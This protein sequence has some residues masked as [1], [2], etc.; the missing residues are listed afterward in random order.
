M[1]TQHLASGDPDDSRK[2][3]MQDIEYALARQA[4][5]PGYTE[6]LFAWWDAS[7]DVHWEE[8]RQH[9]MRAAEQRDLLA[10]AQHLQTCRRC[11]IKWHVRMFIP[12]PILGVLPVPIARLIA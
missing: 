4:L 6:H 1:T 11:R 10:L 3:R 7:M 8:Q 12:L 9:A 2:D 5:I